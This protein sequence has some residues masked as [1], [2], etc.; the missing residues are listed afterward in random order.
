MTPLHFA[1]MLYNLPCVKILLNYGADVKLKV[2]S[3]IWSG[4]TALDIAQDCGYDDIAAVLMEE[5]S[6]PMGYKS[7]EGKLERLK[8]KEMEVRQLLEKARA[9]NDQSTP[10]EE[11]FVTE[12]HFNSVVGPLVDKINLLTSKNEKLEAKNKELSERLAE[13]EETIRLILKKINLNVK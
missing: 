5:R 4:K 8:Q 2:K 13:N 9:E 12:S 11:I 7:D 3:G 6:A 1:V 10:N